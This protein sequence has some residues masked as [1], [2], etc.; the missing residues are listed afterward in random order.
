MKDADYWIRILHLIKHPEGGHFREVYRSPET[1]GEEAL[2]P[3]YGGP[4]SFCTSIYF[5][6][7]GNEFSQLHRL[8]SDE[9][10]HFYTGSSLTIHTISQSGRHS[11]FILGNNIENGEGFQF[12]IQAGQWFGATV[13]DPTS[14][15][16]IG[17]TVSP[18]FDFED[19]ELGDEGELVRLFPQ[20]KSIISKLIRRLPESDP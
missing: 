17:C 3:R 2:P 10:W 19:F 13:N 6:L 8:K 14:Y 7:E 4:R 20:H 9:L 5:L 15:S 12:I 1:L 16:L 11:T 18:G